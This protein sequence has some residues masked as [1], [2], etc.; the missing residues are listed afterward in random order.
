MAPAQTTHEGVSFDANSLQDLTVSPELDTTLRY[1]PPALSNQPDSGSPATAQK[2][3]P[4]G[5]DQL[6]IRALIHST[7]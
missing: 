6:A 2:M 1:L 4:D 3:G 7:I 5:G